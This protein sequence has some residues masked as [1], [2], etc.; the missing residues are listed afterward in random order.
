MPLRRALQYHLLLLLSSSSMADCAAHRLSSPKSAAAPEPLPATPHR[1]PIFG[2]WGLELSRRGP[3]VEWK[4]G[5]VSFGGL[6]LGRRGPAAPPGERNDAFVNLARRERWA[7][8]YAQLD[9]REAGAN[10]F[11]KVRCRRVP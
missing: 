10:D 1:G 8:V 2:L 4:F 7:E 3:P 11:N 5:H 6:E 9:R